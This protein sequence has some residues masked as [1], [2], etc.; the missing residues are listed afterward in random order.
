MFP[1]ITRDDVFRLETRRLWLRWPRAA[2][3]DAVTAI[4]GRK[5]VAEMTASI[6]HP[7]PNG[8]AQAWIFEFRRSNAAGGS[9]ALVATLNRGGRDLI[10][11]ISVRR[12]EAGEI[13]L[14]YAFGPAWWG[15]GYATEAVQALVDTVFTLTAT[16]AILA[17]ARVVNPASHRVLRKC[18]FA[19]EGSGLTAFEARGGFLPVEHFCLD[20]KAWRS[21]KDWRQPVYVREEI[22]AVSAAS[23]V[24]LAPL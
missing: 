13:V 20:R 7:Y 2:D 24:A 15:K 3:A 8:A 10:G 5:E 16:D 21:L 1:E 9:I 14:G 19:H 6:P 12:G 4:A 22:P 11:T 17:S 23:E 18:G